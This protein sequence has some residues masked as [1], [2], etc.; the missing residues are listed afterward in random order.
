MPA[1][2]LVSIVIPCHNHR[3]ELWECLQSI[4]GQ[5]GDFTVEM[6]VVD[7]SSTDHP[8][9]VCQHFGASYF[10]IESRNANAAR[11]YGRQQA[12]G[13]VIVFF[14]ADNRMKP[15]FLTR[16]L[17]PILRGEAD[18]V[19]GRFNLYGETAR[20]PYTQ[21][22]RRL[23]TLEDLRMYSAIDTASAARADALPDKPWDERL[24]RFDDWDYHLSNMERGLR[25]HYIPEAIY[26]Y[27]LASK[28]GGR[29][30]HSWEAYEAA[31]R[32]IQAKHRLPNSSRA[33]ATVC[34]PTIGRY[35]C[36]KEWLGSVAALDFPSDQLNLFFIDNSNDPHFFDSYLL[37]FVEKNRHR[38]NG[39]ALTV[40]QTPKRMGGFGTVEKDDHAGRLKTIAGVMQRFA[41]HVTT[42]YLFV[43]EDDTDCP[44]DALTKLLSHLKSRPNAVAAQGIE[45]SRNIKYAIGA[46][47]FRQPSLA[48]NLATVESDEGLIR[49]GAGGFFCLAMDSTWAR[50]YRFRERLAPES[51]AAPGAP[52]IALGWDILQSGREL[53][54][55]WS[56]R[57]GHYTLLPNGLRHRLEMGR[58]NEP[59]DS[60]NHLRLLD[61]RQYVSSSELPPP[62]DRPVLDQDPIPEEINPPLGL[63]TRPGEAAYQLPPP[64]NS[65]S[66]FSCRLLLHGVISPEDVTRYLDAALVKS[67]RLTEL[68][69]LPRDEAAYQACHQ[70][71]FSPGTRLRPAGS[72]LWK[73]IDQLQ[74]QRD[75]HLIVADARLLPPPL[76]L[77][78]AHELSQRDIQAAL[79]PLIP[80][81]QRDQPVYL[82]FDLRRSA[83]EY[84]PWQQRADGRLPIL[85]PKLLWINRQ[86]PRLFGPGLPTEPELTELAATLRAL[87]RGITIYL[88]PDLATHVPGTP[89]QISFGSP[90]HG[91]QLGSLFG[92]QI[93]FARLGRFWRHTLLAHQ[94]PLSYQAAFGAGFAADCWQRLTAPQRRR[95]SN[96]FN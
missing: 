44:P 4:K 76:L 94:A 68:V 6:I 50:S 47:H 9:I 51:K 81:A 75:A 66:G 37:P 7:D 96:R 70:A 63:D 92:Q 29:A 49:I 23:C 13:E 2:P 35:Y 24:Y 25:Y 27:H 71:E 42:P 83:W 78:V 86:T 72:S 26:D 30:Y 82:Q 54:M 77:E 93:P 31:R 60:F 10:R 45:R 69:L 41:N 15:D 12:R 79:G 39:L 18:V 89:P 34:L 87:S 52:D 17:P 38:Y 11:N 73:T 84:L 88:S 90:R 48:A 55:D 64:I 46:W 16:S 80:L 65:A 56:I 95:L 19:Y 91:W 8:E 22:N 33:I 57:C 14:D 20:Y 61:A 43:L 3:A 1:K 21:H 5:R 28:E 40:F 67:E 53:L 59:D 62:F 36:V 85:N 58:Y 32:Y 74:E